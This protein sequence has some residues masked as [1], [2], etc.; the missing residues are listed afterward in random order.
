[1]RGLILHPTLRSFNG[2]VCAVCRL[3]LEERVSNA[4]T[5]LSDWL[6]RLGI[7]AQKLC[8]QSMDAVRDKLKQAI[9]YM[10]RNPKLVR[11]ITSSPT[12][13]THSDIELVSE[14]PCFCTA[15]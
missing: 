13:P 8:T 4:G 2:P 11:S 14:L 15:V 6:D 10:E 5:G 12:S 3:G 7:G 1:M 9:L